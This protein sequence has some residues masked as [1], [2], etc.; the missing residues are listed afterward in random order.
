VAITIS[1]IRVNDIHLEPDH[2]RGGYKIKS[3][4]YSLISSA[5]KILAKQTIGG[6]NGMALEPSPETK[7]ALAQFTK[8]YTNDVQSLLGLME[9]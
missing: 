6:Y 5:D 3:A 9:Q 8:L 2:E 4:E 1:G 7:A